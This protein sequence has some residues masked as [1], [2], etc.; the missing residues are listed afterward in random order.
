MSAQ[1][2]EEEA[3]QANTPKNGRGSRTPP[4]E[5]PPPPTEEVPEEAPVEA[6]PALVETPAIDVVEA[7][8]PPAPAPKPA[9]KAVVAP[10]PA[11]VAAPIAAGTRSLSDDRASVTHAFRAPGIDGLLVVGLYDDGTPGEALVVLRQAPT[12]VRDA[13]NAF[14]DALNLAL[15]YGVPLSPLARS[16]ATLASSE[17]R[18]VVENLCGY[19]ETRF[20]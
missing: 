9:P 17:A 2:F 11:P 19:L 13:L 15:P 12:A 1:L 20:S 10:A 8:A 3:P 16:L 4:V 14:A 6:A 7:V 18:P 5:A